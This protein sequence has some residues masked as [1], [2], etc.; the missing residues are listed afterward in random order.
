MRALDM[1]AI[2]SSLDEADQPRVILAWEDKPAREDSPSL[3]KRAPGSSPSRV[4]P[5]FAL[6]RLHNLYTF[7]GSMKQSAVGKDMLW[8]TA[9]WSD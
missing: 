9:G 6:T 8:P 7:T 1:S 4:M 5:F 2:P 3:F